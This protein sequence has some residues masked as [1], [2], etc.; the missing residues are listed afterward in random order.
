MDQTWVGGV[1]RWKREGR[2]GDGEKGEGGK[3]EMEEGSWEAGCVVA[4]L[5]AITHILFVVPCPFLPIPVRPP[6]VSLL[7]HLLS[8]T[9]AM[10]I[11]CPPGEC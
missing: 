6:L 11:L 3:G 9:L 1:G 8:H 4:V 5:G 7:T 2:R 10:S